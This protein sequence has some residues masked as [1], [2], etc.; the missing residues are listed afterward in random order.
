MGRAEERRKAKKQKKNFK[1]QG[2][3][4]TDY[5]DFLDRVNNKYYKDIVNCA[6][7]DV[8]SAFCEDIKQVMRDNKIS[9]ERCD[10]IL[11]ETYAKTANREFEYEE[12][13]VL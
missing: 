3:T 5:K 6:F 12:V 7:R 10:K 13:G 1:K 4:N 11:R 9:K 8:Y 2:M